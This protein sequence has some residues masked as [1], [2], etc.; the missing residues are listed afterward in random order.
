MQM[1]L[2][3]SETWCTELVLLQVEAT[4][5]ISSSLD[6]FPFELNSIWQVFISEH[7]GKTCSLTYE[8]IGRTVSIASN[9]RV[10]KG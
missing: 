8:F 2:V 7:D 10:D 9:Y 6:H 1:Y 3:I 4:Q 5:V